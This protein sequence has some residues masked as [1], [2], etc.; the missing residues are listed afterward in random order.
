M[1]Y[2]EFCCQIPAALPTHTVFVLFTNVFE[3]VEGGDAGS[4]VLREASRDLLLMSESD[5]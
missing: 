4:P 5:S 2:P 3:E 1:P